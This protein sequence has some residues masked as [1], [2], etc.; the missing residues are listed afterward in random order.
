M[1][2]L[3][4]NLNGVYRCQKE[5]LAVMV[6]QE[7]VAPSSTYLLRLPPGPGVKVEILNDETSQRSGS[8][9]RPW[10]H[11]QRCI[12]VRHRGTLPR[13]GAHGVYDGKAR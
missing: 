1:R 4:V 10:A 9:G 3:D 12:H 11:H 7:Y 6:K 5:E 8:E 13:N 2:I